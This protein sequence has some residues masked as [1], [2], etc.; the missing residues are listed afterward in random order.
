MG[1]FG[2][3]GKFLKKAAPVI[4]AI[5][6]NAILPG[7]GGVVGGSL[8]GAVSK[9]GKGKSLSS[10]LG[11]AA[12]GGLGA[13]GANALSAGKGFS[14]GGLVSGFKGK[15][16]GGKAPAGTVSDDMGPLTPGLSGGGGGLGSLFKNMS[17]GDLAKLGIA[18][19][20]L[21]SSA[22][23]QGKSDDI[24]NRLL[25]QEQEQDAARAPLRQLFMDRVQNLPTQGPNL[26]RLFASQNP[27]KRKAA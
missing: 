7:V 4:G 12:V 2:K 23:Q 21:Y 22:K 6:G 3:V 15:F 20:G 18:G 10:V 26:E 8:G 17:P 27:F 9:A 11:G 24:T 25:A 13:A 19:A 1:I 16:L 5:A 14:P